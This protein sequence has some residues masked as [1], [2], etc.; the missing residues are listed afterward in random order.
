MLADL[1]LRDAGEGGLWEWAMD[2]RRSARPPNWSEL[3]RRLSVRTDGK[4]SVTGE[5]LRQWVI[6]AEDER[7]EGAAK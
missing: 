3:A 6:A 7:P 2:Q 5:V 1:I 4:V